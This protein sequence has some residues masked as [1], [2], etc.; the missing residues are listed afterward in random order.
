MV[1]KLN[2]TLIQAISHVSNN[3]RNWDEFLP[4]ACFQ[5]RSIKNE[6]THECPYYLLFYRN[7]RMPIDNA[8]QLRDEQEYSCNDVNDFVK[9]MKRRMKTARD[10]FDQ[11]REEIEKEKESFNES[12][13]KRQGFE[14]C[15]VV[16]ILKRA[17]KKGHVKKL[18]HL[19]RGPYIIT[20]KLPNNI[21]Y[22]VELLSNGN[23]KRIVHASNIK[24]YNE[25]HNAHLSK[26]LREE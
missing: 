23:D 2:H 26:H 18:S 13:L 12:I 5:Y 4:Y 21:N 19:W 14:V 3:Q 1:E 15:D 6:T 24:L 16:L 22:E 8:Y 11:Q 9:E 17:V 20:D 25:P 7:V 10:I